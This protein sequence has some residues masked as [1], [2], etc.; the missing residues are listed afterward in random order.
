M[1]QSINDDGV[2]R[3]APATPGLSNTMKLQDWFRIRQYKVEIRQI[4]GVCKVLE[5]EKEGLLPTGLTHL[6]TET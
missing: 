1:N 5:K 3:T 4:G 6:V 2:C